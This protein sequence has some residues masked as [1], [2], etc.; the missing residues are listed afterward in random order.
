MA[1]ILDRDE[2]TGG[3][4]EPT[5][6]PHLTLDLLR[7]IPGSRKL[8][9]N[10]PSLA[11]FGEAAAREFTPGEAW[12]LP[13]LLAGGPGGKIATKA[14]LAG[15]GGIMA[16][17]AQAG[18]M[19][20]LLREGKAAARTASTGGLGFRD[21]VP[22]PGTPKAT[23]FTAPEQAFP[24]AEIPRSAGFV[25]PPTPRTESKAKAKTKATVEGLR[26]KVDAP[27]EVKG[28]NRFTGGE[29][30]GIYRG[31]EAFGGIT[32]QKLGGMRADYLR[33]MEE[34]AGQRDWYDRASDT[35]LRVTG[36]DVDKADKVADA[37]S[38][39]SARTPVGSNLMY[40]NKGWNQNLIGEPIRTGG[41][42]N[43][44]GQEIMDAWARGSQGEGFGMKRSPYRAGL[45]VK[46]MGPESVKRATHDIHDVR[47]WGIRDPKT[48]EPWSKGVGDA[49]HRFLDEQAEYVRDKANEETL[50]GL[51]DWNL[52]N[53]QAAAWIAQKAKA[54]GMD[55]EEAGKDYTDF[56]P[57]YSAGITREWT[58]GA[59]TG[60]MPE[61][62]RADPALKREYADAMEATVRGPEGIDRLAHEMGALVDTTLP[63]RGLYEGQV[64][65]GY[66]TQ[67]LVGKEPGGQGM[68]PASRTVAESVAGA[69]GLIGL[70]DQ[71][72]LNYLGGEAPLKSAGAFQ[73]AT[74]L[75]SPFSDTALENVSRIAA[76]HGGD[77]AQVDPRGARVLSFQPEGDP[78]RKALLQALREGYGHA[79]VTPRHAETSLFPTKPGSTWEKPDDWSSKPFIEKIE[80]GGPKMVEG[81]D[82]AMQTMAPEQLAATEAIAAKHG[83][84]QQAFYKPMME[85]L[86]TGGLSALKELV[87]KGIVPVAAFAVIADQL[88]G[89]PQPGA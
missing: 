28:S 47:A 63:N 31:T 24:A 15:L 37:A 11:S 83:F 88:G 27:K 9:R 54:K 51:T 41:F 35:I 64:N 73:I 16:S 1:S 48:G 26:G 86:S 61:L 6:E 50:A 72:A 57:D 4:A 89:E 13:L 65:P 36:G 58:P 49:G 70:Q 34:G 40:V 25:E 12:E 56:I 38:I 82:R 33:S 18:P 66:S 10:N 75:K 19:S 44:H 76:E 45:S 67:L 52:H 77:I 7:Q 85:A 42:P 78:G 84:T 29:N 5:P 2:R 21:V 3:Y 20:R 30:A 69:H 23:L 43:V 32:P 53:S 59:T 46:W 22:E 55:V 79:D 60:H 39:T 81:F 68:D 62:L 74:G 71:S 14:A 17:D 80:G 87:A 8:A